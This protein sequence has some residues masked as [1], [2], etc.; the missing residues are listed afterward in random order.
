MRAGLARS[1]AKDILEGPYRDLG[2]GFVRLTGVEGVRRA[3]SNINSVEDALFGLLRNARDAGAKNIYVA[4]SLRARRYRTLTV[5]DDGQGIPETYKDL[6][7]EP[8]V[9]SRHLKPA[10][11]SPVTN[12]STNGGGLSLY[13]IKNAAVEAKVLSTMRPTSIQ[14]T[15]DTRSLPERALQSGTRTS[16]SNLP[17]TIRCF[18]NE[19]QPPAKPAAKP[20]VYYGSPATILALLIKNHIIQLKFEDPVSLFAKEGERLGLSVSVRTVQRIVRGEVE[21]PGPVATVKETETT[22]VED[23]IVLGS[24]V[25][26]A[27]LDLDQEEISRITAI[28]EEAALTRYLEVGNLKVESR[29]GEIVL[30]SRV[31]EP[32]EEY[33]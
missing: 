10:F 14:V 27:R 6:V 25:A 4:S 15:L 13:H 8:G 2:S 31:Y 23:N 20:T 12:K 9:T 32:E 5:I 28:L 29:P 19:S 21:L 1:P 18:L 11:P 17:A 3:P 22:Q 24:P 7:F 33:E 16:N 26:R 30:R